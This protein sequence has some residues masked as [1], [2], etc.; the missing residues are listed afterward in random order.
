MSNP[1]IREIKEHA[2]QAKFDIGDLI[3]AALNVART[4]DAKMTKELL[5]RAIRRLEHAEK[6]Q[7]WLEEWTLKRHESK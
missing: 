2:E 7:K 5:E 1:T 3:V 4:G 6:H